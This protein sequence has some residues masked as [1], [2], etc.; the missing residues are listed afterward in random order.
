VTAVFRSRLEKAVRNAD[1]EGDDFGPS[2][3]GDPGDTIEYRITYSNDGDAAAT[4]VVVTDD[5]PATTTFVSC[6]PVAT[7]AEAGGT[8]TWTIPVVAAGESVDLG[9][10]VTLADS[11]DPGITVIG[12]VA[13]VSVGGGEPTDSNESTVAVRVLDKSSCPQDE[14]VPGGLLTYTMDWGVHGRDLDGVTIVD[15]LPAG[16]EFISASPAPTSAPAAGESGEVVWE[17]G[18]VADGTTGTVTIEARAANDAELGSTLTNRA[19]ISADGI[20]AKESTDDVLVTLGSESGT[21]ERAFGASLRLPVLGE[22]VK[23]TPDTDVENPDALLNFEDPISGD[24]LQVDLLDVQE[25]GETNSTGARSNAIAT[26]GEVRVLDQDPTDGEDWLVTA[27]AVRAVS[28]SF[29]DKSTAGSST[30]GSVLKHVTIDGNNIGTIT[31]PTT[32]TLTDPVLGTT[33][34]I[35]LLEE[36]RSGAADGVEQPDGDTFSS[37]MSLNGIHVNVTDATDEMLVD[38][39]VAHA[40]SEATFRSG[41]GCGA[42]QPSVSGHGF[43]LGTTADE[44]IIDDE[45][46]LHDGEVA[47]TFL[48]STGGEDTATLEHAGPLMN[49]ELILAE[50]NTAFSHT[51]GAVDDEAN[52]AEAST[53]A[54]IEDL[55]LLEHQDSPAEPPDF[56]LTAG[57][58]RAEVT[59]GATGD[60][61]QEATGSTTL[62][63]VDIEGMDVCEALGLESTCTPAPNTPL[64]IGGN[65][66]V[67]L[68]EQIPG[69]SGEGLA[70]MTVNAIHIYVLGKDNP[71]DLPVSAEVIISSAQA[72]ARAAGAEAATTVSAATKVQASRGSFPLP[73]SLLGEEPDAQPARGRVPKPFAHHDQ[74]ARPQD[75][76]V[77]P[78]EQQGTP[79]VSIPPLPIL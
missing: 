61:S 34:T 42:D 58:I 44:T 1:L 49:G 76:I 23:P 31:E 71:L 69:P 75:P 54:Q 56:V 36:T 73:L 72:G 11:Y 4:G 40:D 41:L 20:P 5:V 77:V 45:N 66:L 28:S 63:D 78:E 59:A 64:Q 67:V 15:T 46:V 65:L 25:G 16:V 10:T 8:V 48:P 47:T 19:R 21:D 17:F 62:V 24:I 12:N 39:K 2:T 9:M 50:S 33:T 53:E 30:A 35:A 27:T 55:K 68:N 22:V 6:S 79:T 7:C 32:I 29:A 51:I 37:G 70:S 18:H 38:L 26:T 43:A 57:L 14:V 60:P 3:V 13:T 52:T 74:P